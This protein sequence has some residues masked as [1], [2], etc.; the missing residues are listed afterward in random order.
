MTS[1]ATGNAIAAIVATFALA[2]PRQDR[3]PELSRLA[4]RL[5][6]TQQIRDGSLLLKD[7]KK[8][9]LESRYLTLTA[10]AAQYVKISA[11]AAK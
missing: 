7:I 10:A 6:G 11:D 4:S 5:I 2:V 9:Q 3:L 8:G 1:I